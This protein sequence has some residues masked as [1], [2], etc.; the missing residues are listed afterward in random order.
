MYKKNSVQ[1]SAALLFL[2]GALKTGLS[3]EQALAAFVNESPEPLRSQ[4]KMRLGAH[5]NSLSLQKKIEKLFEGPELTLARA[6]LLLS[7]Q[8]GGKTG[9]ILEI[10]AEQLQEQLEMREKISVLTAQSVASAWVVGLSPFGLLVLMSF[11]SPDYI[12][13][14]FNTRPGM[15]VLGLVVL[16][17]SVG[18][19]LVQKMARV[20]I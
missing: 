3:L 5:S 7:H 10:C 2:A 16:L 11:F 8:S 12:A 20:D 4:L 1:W 17:V 14:L 13:P 19:Y 9:R 15:L 6:A 18:L